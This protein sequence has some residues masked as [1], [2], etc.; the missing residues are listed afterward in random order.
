MGRGPLRVEGGLVGGSTYDDTPHRQR[1][2]PTNHLII[3]RES[4][5]G[6]PLYDIALSFAGEQRDYVRAVASCLKQTEVTYFFDEDNRVDLWGRNLVDVLDRTYR[7]RAR[8]VVMFVS[9]AYAEKVWPN[10]ERQS[11]QS[12]AI[13]EVEPYILPVRFDDTDLPGLQRSVSTK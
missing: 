13:E 9:R 12:R 5:R 10:L 11:A 6:S 8:F 1:G 7:H 3:V 2:G 4:H